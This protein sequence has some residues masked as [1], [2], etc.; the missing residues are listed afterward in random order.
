MYVMF[1]IDSYSDHRTSVSTV[2]ILEVSGTVTF[3]FS[4]ISVNA[5]TLHDEDLSRSGYVEFIL[6]RICFTSS[7]FNIFLLFKSCSFFLF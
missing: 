6:Q 5:I 7:K 3:M 4:V 2:L 1:H